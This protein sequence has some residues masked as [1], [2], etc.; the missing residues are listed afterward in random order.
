MY[1]N[2]CIVKTLVNG[3][4]PFPNPPSDKLYPLFDIFC[5]NETE[6]TITTGVD[7]KTIDDG[8][9]SCRVLLERGC[10]SVILTMGSNGAIYMDSTVHFHVAVQEKVTPVDTTVRKHVFKYESYL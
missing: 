9:K 3:A 8:K 5:L 2:E 1:I 6:A 7:V 4:P 10:G